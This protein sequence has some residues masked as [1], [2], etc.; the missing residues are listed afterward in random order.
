MR[1]DKSGDDSLHLLSRGEF[2]IKM[3]VQQQGL[4]TYSPGIKYYIF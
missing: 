3:N 2:R 1:R 4:S